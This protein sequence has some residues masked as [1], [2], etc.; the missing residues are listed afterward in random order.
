M[1]N[2]ES[3]L[4][5]GANRKHPHEPRYPLRF[6]RRHVQ[7]KKDDPEG[8]F[9][10]FKKYLEKVTKTSAHGYELEDKWFFSVGTGILIV[11]LKRNLVSLDP[12]DDIVKREAL[13]PLINFLAI[14]H[15]VNFEILKDL[16]DTWYLKVVMPQFP[17]E[18]HEEIVEPQL[19]QL[20]ETW[21][22]VRT[23][24]IDSWV[25]LL[26]GLDPVPDLVIRLKHLRE[27]MKTLGE[28]IKAAPKMKKKSPRSP[29]KPTTPME[30]IAKAG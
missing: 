23:N 16:Q 1:R 7:F 27:T 14:I 2:F 18:K 21:V 3:Y 15:D 4:K 6:F 11:D 30:P 12:D 24:P 13:E 28:I 20:R 9:K 26:I 5:S 29:E 19:K 10:A 8:N 22:F 17:K 25:H